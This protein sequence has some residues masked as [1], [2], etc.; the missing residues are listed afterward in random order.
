MRWW[1]RTKREQ[2]LDREL[3]DHIELEAQEQHDAGLA[4][5]AARYAARRALGNATLVK[6]DVREMWGSGPVERLRQDLRYAG[7]TLKRSPGFTSVA[8]LALALG[9]GANT[10]IFSVVNA[11]LLRPLPFRD[12]GS[13]MMLDEKWLPR[14]PHFEATPG[15]FLS[16]QQQNGAFSQMAAFAGAAFNLTGDDRPE[17]ISGARVSANLPSL[18][19]VEPILGRSFTPEED[20]D[21]NDRVVLLGY[22]LWQRRFAGD[23]HVIGAAVTLNSISFTIVGVMPPAFRFP[24]DA[25]IWRPIAFTPRDL[26]SGHFVWAIGRLKP[27]MTRAQAQAGMD[28]IMPRLRQPQ[29]WSANVVPLLDYYVGEVQ[30]AL[31]VLLGAA[32]FVLLIA[33]VNVANLLLTRGAVRQKE[34]CLRASLGASR[35][36]II[37]Q[38]LTESVLL[39][40]MGGVLGLLLASGGISTIK[41]LS[42]ANIPRLDQA[43]LDYPVLLFTLA[44]S[45]LTGVLFGLAPA[46]RLARTDL[47]DSLKA[48]SRS[49]GAN[50]RSRVRSA[51]VVSEVALALVLLT[52]AG[53]LLK[54]FRRLLD[55][56]PGFNPES[57][58]SAAINL[59]TAKYREPFQQTQF[60]DQLLQR[61]ASLPGVRQAAVSAGL[62]FSSVSDAGV[63]I[64]GRPIGTPESGAPA[65]YYRVTPLYLQVMGIPLIR[66]RF[67][68]ERD[69]MNGPPVVIIN[70]MMAKRFFPNEDPIG[71]R[72]D[73][74]GPT[75][76]REIAGVVGDVKQ[77][78]LKAASTP[79]VY[80]PFFQKPSSSFNLVVRGVGEPMR[81]AE[82]VRRQ[83]LA[84]DRDQPVSKVRTMEEIVARS[85]AQ[86]RLSVFL[87]GLFAFLA[88]VLAAVGIYGVMAYSVTQ[89]THE[90]GIRMALGAHRGGIL[91]LVL[92]QS[93]QVALLGV[94]IGLA[95][96]LLLT[97]LMASLLYE[98]KTTDPVIFAAVSAILLGVALT[99]AF[100]PA[101]RASRVDPMVALRYE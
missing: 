61:I 13:L 85:M 10:A 75:Y 99:A 71:K 53:L 83:V 14:F 11:V 9:I 78:G 67:F 52:G 1:K 56:R 101:R 79:Q 81:L 88:L 26:N 35:G 25:E 6:E 37:Q 19:G 76:L 84:I 20:K 87:L 82:A 95:A 48:G 18:L 97:R 45:T 72:L 49:S 17:R 43:E 34:L 96:S 80:E 66:G 51:L 32:G 22:N 73:I 38:L 55:V 8:L 7:R 44:L 42:L 60:V 58:L 12:P 50:V 46:L 77:A 98:V 64:D 15:D 91:K 36:R 54:S 39:S 68:T 57:V 90:I 89:R 29:V 40:L 21:G 27:G 92:G 65:N 47:H 16:W 93:L 5:D 100:V 63:R 86:D 3:R 62:P 33:C 28:L 24:Q 70:E 41:S 31:L 94:G 2:D 69:V 74:S 23:P 59:P 30:T 4:P